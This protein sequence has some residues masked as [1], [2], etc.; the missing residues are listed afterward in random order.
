[1]EDDMMAPVT[2]AVLMKSVLGPYVAQYCAHLREGR[3]AAQTQRV[4]LCCIAHVAGWMTTE[5]LGPDRADEEAGRRFIACHLPCCTCP[6]PVRR[7]PHEIRAALT[8]LYRV[9]RVCGA[10]ATAS[11]PGDP[12][13]SELAAFDRYMDTVRGLADNTRDQRVRIVRQFLTDRFQTGPIVLTDVTAADLRRFVLAGGER[14]SAGTIGVMA[15]AL[16]SYLRFRALSGEPVGALAESIPTAAHWR[17]AAL[18][19][20][21]SQAEI[22]QLLGSFGAP[23]PSA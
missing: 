13:R 6:G 8:H 5:R 15:G 20:V 11:G 21:L 19:E 9:L 7:M 12:L 14:R 3:Y 18:P 23:F 17:L 22:D 16:R 4:Y 1:M 10:L 2:R